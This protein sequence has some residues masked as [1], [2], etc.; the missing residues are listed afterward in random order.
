MAMAVVALSISTSWD[1]RLLFMRL[2]LIT[3]CVAIEV[4]AP[5]TLRFRRAA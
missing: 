4:A 5:H 1:G 2:S 3:V